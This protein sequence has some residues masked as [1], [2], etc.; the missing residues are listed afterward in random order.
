M[1]INLSVWD[2]LE[3]LQQ[4]VYKSGHVETLRARKQ[5]FEEIEGPI[6]VLWWIPAGATPTVAE[7][8]ERLQYLKEHGPTPKRSASGPRSLLLTI[9]LARR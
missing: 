2:S 5:W 9:R 7:A 6:L 3:S 1:A 4:F 8:Q